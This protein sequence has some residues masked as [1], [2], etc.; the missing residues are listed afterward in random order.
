MPPEDS[1]VTKSSSTIEDL[2][3][4]ETRRICFIKSDKPRTTREV[5]DMAK[6]ANL[7][8]FF[9]KRK[10]SNGEGDDE[11]TSKRLSEEMETTTDDALAP[12]EKKPKCRGFRLEWKDKYPWLRCDI[13]DGSEKM[14]CSHCEKSG[15]KNGFTKGSTNMRMSS[16]VEHSRCNDH[17]SAVTLSAQRAAMEGHCERAKETSNKKLCSQ[18][19]VV[20]YMAKKDIACHQYEG[21]TEL[22]GAVPEAPDFVTGDGIY[23]HS[24]PVDDME[25]ALESVVMKQLDEKLKGSDFIGVIIDETVN[26]TVNKKL[27]IYVKMEVQGRAETRLLG[28]Y[29]VQSGTAQCIFNK[30]V[31]VLRERDVEL[32]RVIALGSDG[33]SV[34]M[35]KRNGVGALLKRESACSIQVHCIAHRVALAAQ[36]AAKSVDQIGAYKRTVASVY[37]FY[38]HSASRTNRLRQLTAA[39]SDEDMTSLKQP[40]AVRWL[41]LHKAVES[42]KSNWPALV[43]ELNEEAV[44][45]NAPAQGI[46]GQ[47]QPYSFIALTHTLADV[48]PVMTKLNLVFQKEDVNLA[49]IRPMVQ[50]SVAALTQLRDA[51]GPEE[52]RFQADCQDDMY[53]E[54]KVTHAGDRAVQAFRKARAHYIQHLIDAL[55]DRFPEDSLDLLNCLDVLLNPSRYPGTQSALQEYAETAIQTITD[56]FGKGM[57]SEDESAPATAPLIDATSARRDAVAVMTALRGYGGLNFSM[58]C[59]VLIRDFGEIYPEWAQLAKIA[60]VI[61]VSSVPAERGFSLQNRIKT[62]QRSRLGEEKVTRLMRIA[63]CA[64]TLGSFDFNSAAAH[65]SAAKMHKK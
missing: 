9:L 49:T 50:A 54:V 25:K 44:G 56:R 59:E 33:A 11:S 41:S 52:E 1:G 18:L 20:F 14:F 29:D 64:E 23:R 30:L 43:M 42:I 17:V 32:S 57:I 55:H 21:L 13:I 28:N 62:A 65:F 61:P 12:A 40:C 39:L 36:D 22:L 4:N 34:M 48:L 5:S 31:E 19:K 63:S 53:R 10:S 51:P 38:K 27:I 58:A 24:G 6:Q 35:G 16:L 46:L 15:R 37:S 26:I 2:E 7:K 45:G 3:Q 8:S 60:C 47:I